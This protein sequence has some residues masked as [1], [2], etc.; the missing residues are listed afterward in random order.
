MVH[1]NLSKWEEE[2]FAVG[3]NY[4][5]TFVLVQLQDMFGDQARVTMTPE[6]ARHMAELLIS[7]ADEIEIHPG[8]EST[9]SVA[10]ED[11]RL[12]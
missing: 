11:T 5:K 3:V 12:G 2:H 7:S 8:K 1:Y 9:A 4:G 10:N 6:E